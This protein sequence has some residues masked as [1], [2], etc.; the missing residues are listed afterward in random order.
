MD[1][2]DTVEPEFFRSH[3]FENCETATK[4][5]PRVLRLRILAVK[6]SQKPLSADSERRKMTGSCVSCGCADE[7]VL[8]AEGGQI[9]VGRN[10]GINI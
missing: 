10:H 9:V 5:A 3:D 8:A 2:L 4:Y 6:N 7:A 1:R